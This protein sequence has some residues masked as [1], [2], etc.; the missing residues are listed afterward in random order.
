M[1]WLVLPNDQ[2]LKSL[3]FVSELSN[4]KRKE[5]KCSTS[6]FQ[7]TSQNYKRLYQ[8]YLNRKRT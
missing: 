5:D 1:P 2:M 6:V 4:T 3:Y 7:A 8:H